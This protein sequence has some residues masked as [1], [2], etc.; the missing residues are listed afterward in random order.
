MKTF[1]QFISESS[2]NLH[3]EHIEDEILNSGISGTRSAI[4]FLQNLR[5]LLAGSSKSS[6]NVTVKWDGAPA[7]FCGTNPENGK[8]FVGTKSVFNKKNPKINY[9]SRD[10]DLNHPASGLNEKLKTA[11]KYFPKL[12]IRGVIQGDL[13]FTEDDFYLVEIDGEPMLSFKPNTIV[14]TVPMNT[15]LSDRILKSK[16]GV[17][18][19]T[20]YSGKTMEEMSASFGFN[21]NILAK[22]DSVWVQDASFR[23]VSGSATLTSKETAIVTSKLSEIGKTFRTLDSKFINLIV[24]DAKIN[25]LIKIYGNLVIRQGTGISNPR[26]HAEGLLKFIEERLSGEINSLKTAS[27]RDRKS[28]QLETIL[29]FIKSNKKQF[30]SVFTLQKQIV[31]AKLIL[32]RKLEKVQSLGSFIE[33]PNGFKVT[34]PEGFVAIDNKSGK[35]VKL[36][37]RLEFS[38]ANF[39]ANKNWSK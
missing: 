25:S 3:L 11:L 35:A 14:Y 7:I 17:V 37:D 22:T 16:I 21:P 32:L 13:L 30:I 39:T 31:E 33:T 2:K 23:N 15:N 8:F 36:V 27:A 6:V 20:T 1:K 12:N 9:T 24:T 26:T 10:I 4:V 28:K 34:A 38:A 19:H 18:F 5:N 29:K